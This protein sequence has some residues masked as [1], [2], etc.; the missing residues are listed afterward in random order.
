MSKSTL[1]ISDKYIFASCFR[2]VS[3]SKK[4]DLVIFIFLIL[5]FRLS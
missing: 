3:D 1:R 4:V 5:L 2:S